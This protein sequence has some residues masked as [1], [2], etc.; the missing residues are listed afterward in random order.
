MQIESH[1]YKYVVENAVGIPFSKNNSIDVLVNGDE[2]F[3][4]MLQAIE[5][6]E[7]Q[8]D[9]LTFI[10][11]SGDI[12]KKF[13]NSLAKKADQGVKVRVILDSFGA[14]FMPEELSDLMIR[15][16]V[17][18]QWFRPLSRWRIWKGDNRTHR[19]VLICDKE[20]AFTG[21]VG[22]AR[23]WEGNARDPSEWRETHF[24]IEG[25]AVSGL[26]AAF[27]ENWVETMGFLPLDPDLEDWEKEHVRTSGKKS[28]ILMQVLRTAASVR[29]SDII[30]LYQT[31]IQVAR[32]NIYIT[33]AYFNPNE[34]IIQ[35]LLKAVER[36]V[37]VH[38]M[39]PGKYS[40]KKVA[41][42]A[43][44][45]TFD[46]LLEG[47]VNLWYYQKTMLHAK[48]ITVDYKLSCIGSA[49]FNHRSMLKDDELNIVVI[50]DELASELNKHFENDLDYCD[51]I[52]EDIWNGRSVW[53]KTAEKLLALLKQEI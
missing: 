29:W 10:Y 49:N 17:D 15:N 23:E 44:D 20:V 18:L 50:S 22:I 3:P 27:M 24:R 51:K 37:D 38:V 45:R 1:Q 43:G 36:G 53:R 30:M 6:A 16:G 31:L 41:K 32:E 52:D 47:G 14:A 5:E 39:M 11:W 33:T 42:L 40:D 8:V 34:N 4:A 26:Q 19:K 2:I 28:K 46:A 21:G 7:H 9:F 48:I 12:A 35:L 25:E 13:A